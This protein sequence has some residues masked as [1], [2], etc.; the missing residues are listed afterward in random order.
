VICVLALSS[1]E[2]QRSQVGA[3]AALVSTAL[4]GVDDVIRQRVLGVLL[5]DTLP[6]NVFLRLGLLLRLFRSTTAL[7]RRVRTSTADGSNDDDGC[8]NPENLLHPQMVVGSVLA[9]NEPPSCCIPR[10]RVGSRRRART[11]DVP[12]Q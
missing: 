4:R 9:G 3:F 8:N 6:H 1:K 10:Q 7:G 12:V 11:I 5:D 2:V